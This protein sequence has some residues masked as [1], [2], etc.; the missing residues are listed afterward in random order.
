MINDR[1]AEIVVVADEQQVIV[2]S[3]R[4]IQ[5]HHGEGFPLLR[6]RV[7]VLVRG[8]GVQSEPGELR[9]VQHVHQVTAGDS[10]D[11]AGQTRARKSQSAGRALLEIITGAEDVRGGTGIHFHDALVE[12]G[13]CVAAETTAVA[14]EDEV[15]RGADGED[16]AHGRVA[17]VR[18]SGVERQHMDILSKGLLVGR[19]G[20]VDVVNKDAHVPAGIAVLSVLGQRR[21]QRGDELLAVGRDAQAFHATV[22]VTAGIKRR[23]QAAGQVIDGARVVGAEPGNDS[24]RQRQDILQNARRTEAIDERTILIADVPGTASSRSDAFRIEA[25][26]AAADAGHEALGMSRHVGVVGE[27]AGEQVSIHA[28]QQGAG[29]GDGDLVLGH[30]AG[31]VVRRDGDGQA[32]GARMI[33]LQ[34]VAEPAIRQAEHVGL[35]GAVGVNEGGGVQPHA[36][37][38]AA[39]R[40]DASAELIEGIGWEPADADQAEVDQWLSL[41]A[42]TGRQGQRRQGCEVQFF[43]GSV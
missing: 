4:V 31:A 6:E 8:R 28:E 29:V 26:L 23:G 25:P 24:I 41:G 38:D 19:R 16:F 27:R 33:I 1:G 39:E 9:R 5:R 37:E 21:L 34:P 7:D 30:R 35:N 14:L 22:V 42:D 13:T 15:L 12:Q 17:V 32:L 18:L 43:H 20:G 3:R 40:I 2:R 10:H 11:V 36:G